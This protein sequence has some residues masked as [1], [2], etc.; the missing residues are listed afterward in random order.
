MRTAITGLAISSAVVLTGLLSACGDDRSPVRPSPPTTGVP[1][2]TVSRLEIVG[3]RSVPPGEIVQFGVT[4]HLSDGSTRDMSSQASWQ[5]Q[6]PSSLTIEG[7]GRATARQVGESVLTARV[8]GMTSTTEVV[9]V[10]AGTFRLSVVARE[11][12]SIFL[13]IR[14]EVLEGRGAG[15]FTTRLVNGRYALYGVAGDAVVRVSGRGYRDH[16]QRVAVTDHTTIEVE[17][18]P[19]RPRA[20]ISGDYTLTITANPTRCGALPAELRVRRYTARVTQL[21]PEILVTLA[22]GEPAVGTLVRN[23]FGG[24]LDADNGRASFN[25]ALNQLYSYYYYYYS[26]TVFSPPPDVVER[27]AET[28]YLVISGG[29]AASVSERSVSGNL[30]GSIQ[31]Y[32][33]SVPWTLTRRGAGCNA[34]HGFVLS[35]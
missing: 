14:V 8:A 22:G 20:M 3:P 24:R 34:E 15:L 35:R 4:G 27:L 13:D 32:E 12:G 33:M 17:M 23:Q 28:T 7:L 16:I 19:E 26:P 9:V 25:L 10:P 6:N 21:G 2:A 30:R 18:V 1:V 29:G 5:S 31:L 11:G